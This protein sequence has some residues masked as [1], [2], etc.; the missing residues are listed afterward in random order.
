MIAGPFLLLALLAAD[1]TK[2]SLV[3]LDF[4]DRPLPEVVAAIAA[5]SGNPVVMQFNTDPPN[6]PRKITLLSAEPVP[7]WDAMD[8]FCSEAKIQRSLNDAG[9]LGARQA[10]V[11]LYGPGGDPGPAQYA[12]PFRLGNLRLQAHFRKSFTPSPRAASGAEVGYHAEF[13]VLPEPRVL[14]I[15][16]GPLAGL[17]A[18]DEMG[19]SL[20]DPNTTDPETVSGP[21]NGMTLGGYQSLVRIKLAAPHPEGK[22]LKLLKGRMPVE[23]AVCP[24]APTLVIGLAD[25]PGKAHK[26]GDLA[27]TVEEFT[28]KPGQPTVLKVVAR[29]EGPRRPGNTSSKPL[30][31][32]RSSMIAKCLEVADPEGRPLAASSSSTSG[33][34]ELRISYLFAP[35]GSGRAAATPKSL[36]I[37]APDWVDWDVPFEFRDVPLP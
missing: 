6:N 19:R 4:K 9:P 13:E 36:R 25:A 22:R 31:W 23:I 2:P 26:T 15:R 3:A 37:Y 17:E 12:G 1:P 34:D 10:N 18:I 35:A 20:L 29:I 33:G 32:T 24:K 8:R 30:V 16:T 7:F 28:A 21:V 14:A 11:T 27:I 5:R